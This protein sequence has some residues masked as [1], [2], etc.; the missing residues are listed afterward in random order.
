MTGSPFAST[1]SRTEQTPQVATHTPTRPTRSPYLSGSPRWS[2]KT[3]PQRIAE[4][5]PERTDTSST[6]HGRFLELYEEDAGLKLP[7]GKFIGLAFPSLLLLCG[8]DAID[9]ES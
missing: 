6:K 2:Q 1:A 5:S 9:A 8:Q 3:S 4:P 7:A